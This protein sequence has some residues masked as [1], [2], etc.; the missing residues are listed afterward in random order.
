MSRGIFSIKKSSLSSP[1]L[2]LWPFLLGESIYLI[3]YFSPFALTQLSSCQWSIPISCGKLFSLALKHSR[4][5]N[6]C[7]LSYISLR[8][9]GNGKLFNWKL[10]CE[11]K[12]YILK[13]AFHAIEP[14]KVNKLD[15]E[16]Y[17]DECEENCPEFHYWKFAFFC[18]SIHFEGG[19]TCCWVWVVP[20]NSNITL[21]TWQECLWN[22]NVIKW[23]SG[24]Q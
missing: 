20:Y 14:L 6:G 15:R 13:A 23:N 7:S 1:V 3:K 24:R 22:D 2:P 5:P 4:S 10:C 21:Q 11:V 8:N 12:F 16:I 18:W 19:A 9:V 17:A